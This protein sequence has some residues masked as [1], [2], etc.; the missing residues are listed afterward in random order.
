MFDKKD[1][2]NVDF[3]DQQLSCFEGLYVIH[4]N[5]YSFRVPDSEETIRIARSPK[6][7]PHKG[8]QFWLA[9]GLQDNWAGR[10]D[11]FRSYVEGCEFKK[12]SESQFNLMVAT[13]CEGLITKPSLPL[14]D[15]KFVGA[16]AMRTIDKEFIVDLFAEYEDEYIHFFWETTA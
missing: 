5:Q 15:S 9:A 1:L 8:L 6:L 10:E 4:F 12:I 3:T 16:L 2:D 13:Q 14:N 11:Y 7:Q